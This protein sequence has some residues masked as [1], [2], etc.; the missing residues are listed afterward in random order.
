MERNTNKTDGTKPERRVSLLP[1]EMIDPR[2]GPRQKR[3]APGDYFALFMADE[4]EPPARD[5]RFVLTRVPVIVKQQVEHVSNE[6][7]QKM[8]NLVRFAIEHG[9]PLVEALPGVMDLKLA[10]ARML[11]A[12]SI[13]DAGWLDREWLTIPDLHGDPQRIWART[14]PGETTEC[15]VLAQQLGLH[16]S[17]IGTL[18]LIAILAQMSVVAPPARR[19]LAELFIEAAHHIKARAKRAR[20]LAALAPETTEPAGDWDAVMRRVRG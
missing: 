10:R 9:T 14:A 18:A 19:Y 12:G 15:A 16:I 5:E 1:S 7:E 11:A 2:R 6:A 20:A 13:D 4:R 3:G 17:P 8:G